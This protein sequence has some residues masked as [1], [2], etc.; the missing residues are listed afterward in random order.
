VTD[1]SQS[2]AVVGFNGAS[3]KTL[4]AEL[5]CVKGRDEAIRLIWLV[6]GVAERF[7]IAMAADPAGMATE[8]FH[9]ATTPERALAKLVEMLG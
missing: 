1:D 3:R 9:G 5:W 2:I 8:I 7:G 6:H 4:D